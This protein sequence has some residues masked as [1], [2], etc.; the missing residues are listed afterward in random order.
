MV[1]ISDVKASSNGD[2]DAR[3]TLFENTIERES[4]VVGSMLPSLMGLP[5]PTWLFLA[6]VVSHMGSDAIFFV[7][8]H[9]VSLQID[10]CGLMRFSLYKIT[11]YLYRSVHAV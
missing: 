7:Q 6:N 5:N 8:N 10:A 2:S 1:L 11:L 3:V 9:V 4:T